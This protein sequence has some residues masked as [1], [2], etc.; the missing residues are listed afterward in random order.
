M[1][2]LRV[3]VCSLLYQIING[4][5]DAFYNIFKGIV[6]CGPSG[7]GFAI[8]WQDFEFG[9]RRSLPVGGTQDDRQ[10]TRLVGIMPCDRLRHL[11]A[12]TEIRGHEVSADQQQ[13]DLICFQVLEDLGLPVG[14]GID[15]PIIPGGDDV[16]TP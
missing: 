1:S 11:D 2:P 8:C 13:N 16:L 7:D 6:M 14:P 9:E 10:N 12:I 5:A 4:F 3:W 15:I